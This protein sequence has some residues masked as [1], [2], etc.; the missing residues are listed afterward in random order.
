MISTFFLLGILL[1]VLANALLWIIS[2]WTLF[3][4]S[5]KPGWATIIPIYNII[6]LL[7]IVKKPTWLVIL[8]FIPLVNFIFYII[9][10]A[11]I[12]AH[13]KRSDAF[14]LGLLLMP[15]IFMFI[16]AYSEENTEKK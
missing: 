14:T 11:W 10:F 16:L 6:V 8:S 7:D 12:S 3:E 9:L 1:L 2:L 15:P 4:K 13:F 5:N